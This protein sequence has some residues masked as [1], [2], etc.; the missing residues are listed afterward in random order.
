MVLEEFTYVD[1]FNWQI[2]GLSLNNLNLI[3]GMNAVGKSRT[4]AA[5]SNVVRFIKGDVELQRDSFCCSMKLV[6]SHQLHYEIDVHEGMVNSELLEKDDEI[7]IRRDSG[8][9]VMYGDHVNPP[10][11]KLI[12]QA[13]RDTKKYLEIEEIIRWAEQASTFIFSNITTSPNSLSPYTISNEPLLP[14]MYK[15]MSEDQQHELLNYMVELG[16][17]IDR[18]ERYEKGNGAEMLRIFESGVKTPLTP[19]DLSNGMFRVFCVLLYMIHCSTLSDARCLMIDDL[20]EGLDYMRS[21]QLGKIVFSYCEKNHIQLIATSNDSFLMD[22]VD[23]KHWNILKR[24]GG[25]VYSLNWMSN[26]DLF[27]RFSR[28]GLSNFDILSSNFIVNNTSHE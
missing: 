9:S 3:V 8:G 14:A 13:R 24:E 25:K 11:N 15:R 27:E 5:I 20:G 19:F 6:N 10:A 17:G 22:A 1:G 4:I 18:I 2:S 21:T 28:T 12:I 16:Y 23:L 26:P 7:L